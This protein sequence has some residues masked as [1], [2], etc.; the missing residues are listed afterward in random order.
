MI[1][2]LGQCPR[3]FVKQG[4]VNFKDVGE[5]AFFKNARVIQVYCNNC[6]ERVI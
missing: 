2:E 6:K 3:C 5:S 4:D 1:L